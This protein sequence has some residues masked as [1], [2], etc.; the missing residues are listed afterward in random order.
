MQQVLEEI[1]LLDL[2]NPLLE[3]CCTMMPSD[4][5]A[6]IIKIEEVKIV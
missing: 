6:K 2:S 1:H 4:L 5:E 3:S